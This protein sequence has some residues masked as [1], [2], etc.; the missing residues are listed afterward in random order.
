MREEP[1]VALFFVSFRSFFGHTEYIG[2]LRAFLK[3]ED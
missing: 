2:T 3:A 1:I